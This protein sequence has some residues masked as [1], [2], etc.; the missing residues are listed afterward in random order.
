M[1]AFCLVRKPFAI[2]A[3]EC[4]IFGKHPDVIY[5]Q[6]CFYHVVLPN[7]HRPGG[8]LKKARRC[9][10][11]VDVMAVHELVLVV[12]FA[13]LAN[14]IPVPIIATIVPETTNGGVLGV[15]ITGS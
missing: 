13:I 8:A 2:H 5:E 15:K 12:D 1:Y 4:T 6:L 3:F 7:T 10:L 11:E 14:H 9:D